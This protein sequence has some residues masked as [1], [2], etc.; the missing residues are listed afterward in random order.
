LQTSEVALLPLSQASDGVFEPTGQT[1]YFTRLPFQG[2]G[3]YIRPSL[4]K[5]A[6]L[7]RAFR[8]G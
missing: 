6:A 4:R 8:L 5:R 3:A 1:L 2:N 7:R